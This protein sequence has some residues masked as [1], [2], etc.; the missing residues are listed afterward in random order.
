MVALVLLHLWAARAVAATVTS[1]TSPLS[2]CGPVDH[3]VCMNAAKPI[4]RIVKDSVDPGA[5]CALCLNM[6]ACAAWNINSE[7]KQ[8]FLRA[9]GVPT[10]PGAKC[11]SQQLRPNPP[12]PP[13]APSDQR[14]RFHFAPTQDFTNDVQGCF[15]DAV[16]NLYHMGFAWHVNGTRG[17]GSAPNRWYHIVSRDLAY[18]EIVSTTPDRAMI[19]PG[20]EAY[21]N[22][23]V[24]TGSVTLVDGVPTALYS[25]HGTSCP[26][27]EPGGAPGPCP[28]IASARAANSSDP[29]RVQWTKQG[30]VIPN[31]APGFRDP[32]TAWM[33]DSKW[34]VLTACKKCNG[35]KSMLG[36]F[37]SADFK[38]WSFTSTPLLAPQLEC[39]DFWPVRT[40]RPGVDGD[41]SPLSAIKLS[42][43]G[44]ELVW[45]GRWDEATQMLV[46]VVPP[47]L[48]S[49]AA[50]KAHTPENG[51]LLDAATY[52]SKSFYDPVHDQ[53]VWSSWIREHFVNKARACLNAT[54][55][56]THTL[57]RALVYDAELAAHVTPPV[58]QTALLRG[59]RLYTLPGGAPVTM[60]CS[61]PSGASGAV[62]GGL[63]L[64]PSVVEAGMQLEILATF[65]LP[66]DPALV[67]GLNV[68]EGGA[69]APMQRASAYVRVGDTAVAADAAR[70]LPALR[71][72]SV[73]VD[74]C[75]ANTLIPQLPIAKNGCS[76]KTHA[77]QTF[78]IKATDANVTLRLFVDHSVLEVY[79][80]GGRGVVTQ[81]TYPTDNARGVS[82]FCNRTTDG[83]GDGA[84]PNATLLALEIW[85]MNSIWVEHV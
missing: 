65:A 59:T 68:R 12:S 2:T 17:I 7:M 11:I 80:S 4:L 36:L 52:A 58:P 37:S 8:C 5:C 83:S 42:Q 20:P 72:A 13:P 49:Q 33:S 27:P 34:R 79:A 14:P 84:A 15:Y 57:P 19:A 23:G 24:M 29:L 41:A 9:T 51:V 78:A 22:T 31:M 30:V 46:D 25:S 55:C 26:G 1:F 35:T 76:R 48:A 69:A 56:S 47:R 54:V 44:K 39:P 40:G 73:A 50:A 66:L 53:Q 18:W 81:R 45:V 6:T 21:D 60:Q 67:V 3:G 28:V 85:P 77:S 74:V 16:H 82:I 32:S 64:P 63:P 70:G 61:A 75:D 43:G 10:N 62:R 71:N 38:T